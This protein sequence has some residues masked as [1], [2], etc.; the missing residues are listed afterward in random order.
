MLLK[1]KKAVEAHQKRI[2]KEDGL[3]LQYVDYILETLDSDKVV[4]SCRM[5]PNAAKKTVYSSFKGLQMHLK[6]HIAKAVLVCAKCKQR[7]DSKRNFNGHVKS[8]K[9]MPKEVQVQATTQEVPKEYEEEAETV[10]IVSSPV[11]GEAQ[12][13]LQQQRSSPLYC[14]GCTLNTNL[15]AC[16]HFERLDP[17]HD[18][19]V[20]FFLYYL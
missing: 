16:R 6:V 18:C 15:L 8:G 2:C 12:D 10:V 17:A 7:F 19:L 14:I 5:C 20:K 1:N 9:P 4:E 11:I 13:V 3:P